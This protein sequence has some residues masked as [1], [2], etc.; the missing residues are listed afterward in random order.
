MADK[1]RDYTKLAQDII[2]LTGGEEN[3]SSVTHCATRLR[4]VLANTPEEANKK[5][6]ALPGVVSVVEKGGQFQVVIGTHVTDVYAAVAQQL[7][8]DSKTSEE[9]AAPKQGIFA[10]VIAAMSGCMSP[11]IYLMAACGLL[12][13]ILIILTAVF[14]SFLETGTYEVLNFMSWTPF[15]FLPVL[16]AVAGSKYFHCNTYIALLCCCALV[17]PSWGEIAARIAD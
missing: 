7:N 17:N 3:I 6:S 11:C 9:T 10:R 8:L 14:P 1:I 16:I 15:T 4:L 13:G 12:Q 5:I 2:E